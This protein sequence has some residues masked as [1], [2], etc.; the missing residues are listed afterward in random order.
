MIA[1]G[2]NVV[3]HHN[4]LADLILPGSAK[5]TNIIEVLM[6]TTGVI[7]GQLSDRTDTFLGRYKTVKR[8]IPAIP[9]S[10]T[11]TFDEISLERAQQII[12]L[13][14]EIVIAYSG[15]IDSTFVLVQFL[16]LLNNTNRISLVMN[17]NSIIENQ[18]FYDN[19]IK[20]KINTI[21]SDRYHARFIPTSDQVLI[22]GD[23]IPQLFGQ[24]LSVFMSNRNDDWRPFVLKNFTDL[25]KARWFMETIQPWLSKAPFEINSIFDWIWWVSFSIRWDN[26][27]CRALKY[28]SSY[29]K[30]IYEN[31]VLSFFRTDDY[32][33]W[34][35]F[36]HDKK[37]KTTPESFKYVMKDNIFEF[38]G[39]A[40]YRDYKLTRW[41][42]AEGL[43]LDSD[44]SQTGLLIHN[45]RLPLLVDNNINYYFKSDILNNASQF[46]KLLNPT[47]NGEWFDSGQ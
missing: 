17:N 3:Y 25:A 9:T 4:N 45:D 22:T 39:D 23:Q 29:D 13:D 31:N 6:A 37:I 15:G 12:D 43:I 1:P 34:S 35:I 30:N 47:D 26:G 41:S 20:D 10:F 44:L 7:L 36:N 46:T 14:K 32:Q 27:R 8:P 38:D 19:Y 33:L 28:N 21:I 42:N 16:K 11:K 18:N 40:D 2:D 5:K 24:S